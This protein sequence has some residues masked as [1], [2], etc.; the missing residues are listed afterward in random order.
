M[1]R[2]LKNNL[3]DMYAKFLRFIS[4]DGYAPLPP[5]II[6]EPS[7]RCNLR[8]KMCFFYG[9]SGTVP[10]FKDEMSLSEIKKVFRNVKQS[11][12]FS[13][14]RI[15][16]TGGEPLIHKHFPEIAAY[17]KKLGF[18]YSI[19]SNFTA[20][21]DRVLSTMVRFPPSD[22][23]VSLDGPAEIHDKIRGVKGAFDNVMKNLG[24]IRKAG[25]FVPVRFNCTICNDNIDYLEK[26]VDIARENKS[27]LNFQH[28]MFL[29]DKHIK[30]HYQFCEK[31]FKCR[32][33]PIGSKGGLNAEEATR[34]IEKVKGIKKRN[35]NIT[36]LPDLKVKEIKDYYLNLEGYTYGSHCFSVWSEARISPN[37]KVYPCFDYYF[38]DLRINSFK[39]VW[40]GGKA[41]RFRKILKRMKLFPGCIRCC[42]I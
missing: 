4:I 33:Y 34:V 39:G 15:H 21:S 30:Q 12:R 22:L 41:R 29:D 2:R 24:K 28:L 19:T 6:W 25:V 37:G 26:M 16:M 31:M 9:S 5:L 40:N 8:C 35:S 11:Y 18:T 36:F 27:D 42:K 10:V 7:Y 23:R 20:L 17:L 13:L 1:K 3:F 38:G 32:P 14:P